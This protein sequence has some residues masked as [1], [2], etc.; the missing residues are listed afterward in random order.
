MRAL[1]VILLAL[2]LLSFTSVE[3]A[4]RIINGP[5]GSGLFGTHVVVLPNRN[6]V[7]TDYAYSIPGGAQQVGSVYLYNPDGVLISTFT[8]SNANDQVGHSGIVVLSNGNYLVLSPYWSGL[9]GAVTWCSAV[10]G[11]SGVLSSS[12]SLVGTG[13]SDLVGSPTL[14]KALTNGNYVVAVPGWGNGAVASVGAVVWGSG[15]TGISG[16]VNPAIAMIGSSANDRVGGE[17]LTLTN[18]NYVIKTIFW[19]DLTNSIVDAGAITFGNGSIGSVGVV[20]VA[21]SFT[22]NQVNT[23][24]NP[25]NLLPLDNGNYLIGMPRWGAGLGALTLAPGDAV[26]SGTP[27]ASRSLVGTLTSDSVGGMDRMTALS[28]SNYVVRTPNWNQNRGAVT[29]GSGITGV[30]GTIS[31][32]NSLVGTATTHQV[33]DRVVALRNGNYVVVSQRWDNGP[34]IDV[35]AITFGSGITGVTGEVSASN[36]LVGGTTLDFLGQDDQSVVA[37]TGGGYTVHCQPCDLDGVVDSGSVTVAPSTGISG[38]LSTSNSLRAGIGALG[39]SNQ[40]FL[41]PLSDGNAVFVNAKWRTLSANTLGSVTWLPAAGITG[42]VDPSNSFIGTTASDQVGFGGITALSNGNYVI[43]SPSWNNPNLAQGDDAGAVTFALGGAPFIGTID[44][45]NSLIGSKRQDYVGNGKVWALPNGHYVVSSN[46]WDNGAVVDAGALTWGSG[47]SGVVG[48]ITAENS[49]VGTRAGDR[50]G[51]GGTIRVFAD[52]YWAA[53]SE[54]WDAPSGNSIPFFNAGAVTLGL[55][56]GNQAGQAGVFNNTDLSGVLSEN[57]SAI[58]SIA[59]VASP[60]N[61]PYTYNPSSNPQERTLIVG[62]PRQNRVVLKSYDGFFQGG[63]E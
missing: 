17:I 26:I 25:V 29:F 34:I 23:G 50:V 46:Q 2:C 43:S 61:I 58:G 33:G 35:G 32:S 51:F 16:E 28:N 20:N 49:W 60:T 11:C 37:L 13:S 8:G 27:N 21:N 38:V 45:S 44:A 47:T 40:F 53:S 22:S 7:V 36:S 18:G 12:N 52:G 1:K 14:V 41:T 62:Q 42:V 56:F 30:T 4:Q 54:Y 31:S 57:N 15:T 3:A 55:P 10:T 48:P 6:F 63:F 9:K 59:G 24:F 5:A 19:D 39:S